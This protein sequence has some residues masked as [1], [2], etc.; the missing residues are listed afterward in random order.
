MDRMELMMSRLAKTITESFNM[1][2][3]KLML[4]LEEKLNLKVDTQA[5]ELFDLHKRIDQLEKKSDD[6]LNANQ[7]MKLQ[8]QDCLQQNGQLQSSVDALEQYTRSD[9]LLLHGLSL[10]Q[11]P[12]GSED[13]Y[14]AIPDTL[15]NLIPG[16]QIT[17]DQIS[18]AHRLPS[19]QHPNLGTSSNTAN[20]PPPIVIRFT[21][22]VVRN[23][24]MSNRRHLKGK[25]I[26]LTDHLTPSRSIL[27]K[28]ANA[29]VRDHKAG[30]AW[31][32]DGKILMK[33]NQDRTV[34]IFSED[35]LRQFI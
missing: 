3:T 35:D 21:R 11:G 6:L 8:L 22:K 14:N 32:Q 16:A 15:N 29:L 2:L 34:Q 25:G 17:P 30:S 9:S 7:A 1:C 18:I 31:S 26:V 5:S 20:R 33:T 23:S 10:P 19:P 28:K 13:L 24:L 4:S 27:L 12:N